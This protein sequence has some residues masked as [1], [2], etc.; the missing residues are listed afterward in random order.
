MVGSFVEEDLPR[1][2][3]TDAEKCFDIH[4]GGRLHYTNE[5]A[6]SDP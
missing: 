6:G 1:K 3:K 2:I 4:N 5:Y